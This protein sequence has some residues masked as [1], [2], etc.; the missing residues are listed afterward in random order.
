[1]KRQTFR[2][3]VKPFSIAVVILLVALFIIGY[4]WNA[5]MTCDYFKIKEV[6]AREGN[7]E[8][9]SY[10]KGRNIFSV[11]LAKEA[12]AISEVYPDCRK[13]ELIRN[14]PSRIIVNF[15]RRKPVALLKLY[16]Y[17]LV[18][19]EGALMNSAGALEEADLPVIMGLETKIFGAKAGKH[20]NIRELAVALSII[21]EL[22][23]SKFM[24]GF[25]IKRIDVASLQNA[26]FVI[27]LMQAMPDKVTAKR[28]ISHA[29]IEIKIG[30]D[31]IKN[32]LAILA[33]IFLQT[34]NDLVSIKYVDLRF[35]E[36]VI[37]FQEV[38][39]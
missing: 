28:A 12:R 34:S 6:I 33:G 9:L 18:D 19:D 26:S 36:P 2:F 13:V 11:D 10:L 3:P 14:L 7:T 8:P 21:E 31:N 1:M 38:K 17:F 24:K 32:K 37:K 25:K 20:Y 29:E 15:N 5:L 4:I 27:P 35:K 22:K 30:P 23:T 16:K 39:K